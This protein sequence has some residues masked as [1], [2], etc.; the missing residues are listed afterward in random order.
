M[1]QCFIDPVMDVGAED[2]D[3]FVPG[4]FQG[5]YQDETRYEMGPTGSVADLLAWARSRADVV[6]VKVPETDGV[7]QYSAG[8]THASD[9]P[10]FPEPTVA[11][12]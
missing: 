4:L 1:A 3:V 6:V 8:A 9:L 12:H 7:Q 11:R 5:V 10:R 2:E